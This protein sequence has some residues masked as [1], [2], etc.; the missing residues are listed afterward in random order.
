MRTQRPERSFSASS[1]FSVV[2]FRK[3]WVGFRMSLGSRLL[4]GRN[5]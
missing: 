3:G 2:N 4:P 5:P 1:A